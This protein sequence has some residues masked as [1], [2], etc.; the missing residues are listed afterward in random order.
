MSVGIG[1]YVMTVIFFCSLV[2][3]VLVYTKKP[4]TKIP[5]YLKM[6][7]LE[8][9]GWE[10]VEDIK[11]ASESYVGKI[12]GLK[13]EIEAKLEDLQAFESRFKEYQGYEGLL[14][15]KQQV[16]EELLE[17]MKTELVYLQEEKEEQKATLEQIKKVVSDPP[18]HLERVQQKVNA[19]I[20]EEKNRAYDRSMGNPVDEKKAD[21]Y[22]LH[23][24]GYTVADIAEETGTE[25]GF[26][27][28]LINMKK[29]NRKVQ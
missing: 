2:F 16:L 13:A 4:K 8:Q 18:P 20:E 29:Y 25:K 7:E 24:L 22:R 11:N 21:I 19:M 3:G 17:K 5:D 26:I 15:Q 28:V 6:D 23:E 9:T 14:T 1:T 12:Q 27:E 10:L